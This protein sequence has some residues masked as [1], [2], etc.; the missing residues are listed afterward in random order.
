[1]VV[2]LKLIYRFKIIPFK[3]PGQVLYRH[4]QDEPKI[5]MEIPGTKTQ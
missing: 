1:M 5:H 4:C 2:L 3:N